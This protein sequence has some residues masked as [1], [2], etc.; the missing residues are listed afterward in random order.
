MSKL[1]NPPS[2]NGTTLKANNLLLMSMGANSFLL[3]CT[4]F[5]KRGITLESKQEITK[6]SPL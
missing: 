6:V 4:L 2:E 5:Q 3:Q 1:F